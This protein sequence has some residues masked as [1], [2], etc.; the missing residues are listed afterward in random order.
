MNDFTKR[1]RRQRIDSVKIGPVA[2]SL[3][4]NFKRHDVP[5]DVVAVLT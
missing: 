2:N 3:S 5:R 1:A 4:R